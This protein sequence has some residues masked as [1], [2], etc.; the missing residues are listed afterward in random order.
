MA[1]VILETPGLFGGGLSG[2]VGR[3]V[4]VLVGFK[5]R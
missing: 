1:C 5:L 2:L 3:L 4:M